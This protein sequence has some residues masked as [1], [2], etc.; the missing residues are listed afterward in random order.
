METQQLLKTRLELPFFPANG[1][2]PKKLRSYELLYSFFPQQ[3]ELCISE[4]NSKDFKKSCLGFLFFWGGGWVGWDY[5]SR[6][7]TD[8]CRRPR[9]RCFEIALIQ[10]LLGQRHTKA[11]SK[12][13]SQPSCSPPLQEKNDNWRVYQVCKHLLSFLAP[14]SSFLI[15]ERGNDRERGTN[16]PRM[17][18]RG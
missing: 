12:S 1:Y 11:S 18:E 5:M 8:T 14:H 9:T 4:K 6:L 3:A 10:S 13:L 15:G 16:W 7:M 17:G 2:M